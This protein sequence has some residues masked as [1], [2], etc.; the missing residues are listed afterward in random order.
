MLD[1][2][3]ISTCQVYYGHTATFPT[4]QLMR[5]PHSSSWV[6]TVAHPLKLLYS[7]SRTWS[8]LKCL[9]TGKKLF[10]LSLY[11]NKTGCRV[12]QDCPGSVQQ[13]DYREEVVLS[14]STARRL[15]AESIKASQAQYKTITKSRVEYLTTN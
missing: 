2:S 8:L 6:L 9:I 3:G 12:H 4:T 5:S 13:D 1:H 7:H 11:C 10:S 14:L 15:A